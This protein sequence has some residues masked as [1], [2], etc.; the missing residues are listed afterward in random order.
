M[1]DPLVTWWTLPYRFRCS[2]V[3]EGMD[4][5]DEE[6]SELSALL[7]EPGD[8]LSLLTLGEARILMHAAHVAG[9]AESPAAEAAQ[10]LEKRLERRLTVMFPEQDLRLKTVYYDY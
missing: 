1:G 8:L 5:E 3:V 9:I 7:D 6:R 2:R 4:R 10:E